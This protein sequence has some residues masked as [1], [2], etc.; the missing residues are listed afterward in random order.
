LSLKTDHE[1]HLAV[2]GKP[3]N[4][5][6]DDSSLLCHMP[7]MLQSATYHRS[8]VGLGR[9]G[10]LVCYSCARHAAKSAPVHVMHQ[11]LPHRLLTLQETASCTRKG[12]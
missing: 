6:I 2:E 7:A 8:L 11:Q 9:H 4:D 1:W 3:W 12:A 10:Q 5:G